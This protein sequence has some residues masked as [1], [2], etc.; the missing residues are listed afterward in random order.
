VR[1]ISLKYQLL[2]PFV[3]LILLV[4][5]GTGWMLHESGAASVN[6]LVRR[7]LI[8]LATQINAATEKHLAYALNTLDSFVTGDEGGASASTESLQD[9]KALESRVS[10]TLRQARETG[11]YVCF[12]GTDGRFVGLYQVN[13]Y[14]QEL[15]VRS[16]GASQRRVYALSDSETQPVFLRTDT[17]D[18]RSRPWY[19]SAIDRTESVWSPVYFDFTS[20]RPVIT[21]ARSIR[22]KTDKVL[23]VAA[24]DI[25][26][27]MV[28]ERLRSLA[29]SRNGI[30]LV[31]DGSGQVLASSEQEL[32]L[33]SRDGKI[34]AILASEMNNPLIRAAIGHVME[35]KN[36][37][38]DGEGMLS[39]DINSEKG[40]LNVA[41]SAVGRPQ[42][43]DWITVVVAPN[44]DFIEGITSSY[45]R[46]LA[47]AITCVLLSLALGTWILN[48]VLRDIQQ[49]ND[50]AIRIGRGENPPPLDIHRS[51]E[52]GQLARS[53]HEMGR[54]LRTD[55]LTGSYN[56]EFLLNRIR[57]MRGFDGVQIPMHQR[58]SLLFIDLD[59][60]KA[61][62]DRHGHDA[63][64]AVLVEIA[65]RL[66]A[67][68]RSS[69]IVARYG[70]DEF[71]VLL[72]D[73][74]TEEDVLAAEEKIRQIAE[75]P[76]MH[77]GLAIRTGI[78]IGWALCPEDGIV[79][80]DLLK[81]ADQRMF[82][83]KKLR[84]SER[85]DTLRTT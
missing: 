80:E 13:S 47:I 61:I 14:L 41:A 51:D 34:K 83:S 66:N 63:G 73:V 18:P 9:M 30:A 65:S 15:Y 59:D 53:F 56:R 39:M 82:S 28:T 1:Y 48:R 24:V 60:F 85:D 37:Q 5:A 62:N 57:L 33:E 75:A 58:F 27:Q 10:R 42:E 8:D 81:I 3:L 69:D 45:N 49:L 70:G 31:M 46:S 17:F 16:P 23:G 36:R 2:L 25:E 68:I 55:R 22:D 77:S 40:V 26:L 71:V 7:V 38:Q 12:G 64:D 4:P 32:L 50:A 21:V 44:S 67:S 74:A 76:I 52:L 20:K 54:N 79:I 72:N 78:S 6:V 19:V 43:I 29:I 11:T 35:W 84:K